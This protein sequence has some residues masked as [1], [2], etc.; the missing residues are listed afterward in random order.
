[1]RKIFII[2]CL[3]LLLLVGCKKENKGYSFEMDA[4]EVIT[5]EQRHC[6][7]LGQKIFDECRAVTPNCFT[8]KEEWDL[9]GC[10]TK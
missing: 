8:L 3:F 7:T 5:S 6:R 4:R 10:E 1:M 9:L 2:V